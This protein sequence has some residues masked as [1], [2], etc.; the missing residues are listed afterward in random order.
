MKY[1]RKIEEVVQLVVSMLDKSKQSVESVEAEYE[2]NTTSQC[3]QCSYQCENEDMLITHMIKKHEE[4]YSC[5]LCDEYF[6]TK[7]SLAFHNKYFHNIKNYSSERESIQ[8]A[9]K[10]WWRN[11]ATKSCKKEQEKEKEYKALNQYINKNTKI[12]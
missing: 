1:G 5:S 8:V 10:S 11:K 2:G 4:S 3:D 6:G 7:S 9:K 12:K